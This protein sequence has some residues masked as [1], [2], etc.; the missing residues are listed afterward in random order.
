MVV[1]HLH[2]WLLALLDELVQPL[3]SHGAI[4]RG[5]EQPV[6]LHLV[7]LR[8]VQPLHCLYRREK[9]ET[10]PVV[11]EGSLARCSKRANVVTLAP[12]VDLQCVCVCV[13]VGGCGCVRA[14]V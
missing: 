8:V 1:L 5:N 10:E 13:W 3:P 9:A 11:G 12:E 7:K 4:S 14:C 6:A 2:L